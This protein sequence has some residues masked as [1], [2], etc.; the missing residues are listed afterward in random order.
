MAHHST[1]LH[2]K[3]SGEHYKVM[4]RLVDVARGWG[5]RGC[6]LGLLDC[7]T[8]DDSSVML[9]SEEKSER[10]EGI[11]RGGDGEDA[12]TTA[13]A[14]AED[15]G[16]KEEKKRGHSQKYQ[17]RKAAGEIFFE[18]YIESTTS[19]GDGDSGKSSGGCLISIYISKEEMM[20]TRP[21]TSTSAPLQ[22]VN[23]GTTQ[24]DE[25][26][27]KQAEKRRKIAT[28]PKKSNAIEDKEDQTRS[29]GAPQ[30]K[31]ITKLYNECLGKIQ[32]QLQQHYNNNN[33]E[34]IT[35]DVTQYLSQTKLFNLLT[36]IRLATSFHTTDSRHGAIQNRL[37]ALVAMIHAH[38]SQEVITGYFSAQP[39]L[40]G[41]LV[42]LLRVMVSGGNISSGGLLEGNEEGEGS[43]NE[44]GDALHHHQANNSILALSDSPVVPYAIRILALEALTAL[45]ARRDAVSGMITN[46]ARQTNVLSE[47]GVGKGQYLG[48]LPTLIR[49]SLAALNSFLLS[50]GAE[51]SK[52]AGK[53]EETNATTSSTSGDAAKDIGLALGLAFLRATAPLLPP[54]QVREERALEFIDSVLTLTS[55]VISVPSGT[56]SLTDCGMIPALVSTVALDGMMAKRSITAESRCSPFAQG[57]NGEESYSETLLKF[58]SAQAIQILEGAIVTHN[59]ALSAFHELKGVDVLVQRL[60]VEV[61]RVK[62]VGLNKESDETEEK[63][64]AS[65]Q[66]DVAAMLL[67]SLTGTTPKPAKLQRHLRASRRVLLFS[68]VNCLTVVFHQ[69]ESGATAAQNPNAPSGGSQIRKPE[70]NSV[71]LEILENIDAYGGVLAALVSTF[72]SDVMNSDPQVVHYVHSSGLAD[73]FLSILSGSKNDGGAGGG[74]IN[75]EILKGPVSKWHEYKATVE[76]SAELIMALPN[77]IT[78]L[79]L[80]E[81]GAKSIADHNPFPAL[82]SIFC[83]PQFVMPNSRCLLNEMAPIVGT[84]LDEL[85]RHNPS[86]KG[87]VLNSVVKVMQRVIYLGKNLISDEEFAVLRGEASVT[88][89]DEDGAPPSLNL[90]TRRTHLLQYSFNISQLVEQILHNEDHTA[91]FVT[92]GGFDALLDLARWTVTPGGAGR[93]LVAHVSCLTAPPTARSVG[94]VSGRLG[95]S[96]ASGTLSVLAKMVVA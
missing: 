6:G 32:A 36:T 41:E 94:T 72:L 8:L 85:I 23:G 92:A 7:V 47:L 58:I 44:D 39:E 3:D 86:L 73:S 37:K 2:N 84:G 16:E 29:S 38:S 9:A 78:A 68:A 74:N 33:N 5:T 66:Q 55:A 80:T 53:S 35:I 65:T 67:D 87:L 88:G 13:S 96:S 63:K 52:S 18:C 25:A 60:V 22:S 51:T 10:N 77:V 27:D 12:T 79:S 21:S 75:A 95:Y 26:E 24:E 11:L 50:D 43:N 93:G 54:R 45:V 59:S 89:M 90:E 69:H 71:L 31:S 14:A 64:K 20:Y 4:R 61:D 34:G 15:N 91:P 40:C 19:G 28:S 62:G 42:D 1:V 83:M 70:L 30:L 76:P 49:Y 82:L 46:V 17:Y 48:V 81:A 57:S 56:A